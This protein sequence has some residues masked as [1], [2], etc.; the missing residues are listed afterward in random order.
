MT[1]IATTHSKSTT[2]STETIMTTTFK[3]IQT[4]LSTTEYYTT[5]PETTKTEA[6]NDIRVTTDLENVTTTTWLL[7]TADIDRGQVENELIARILIPTIVVLLVSGIVVVIL[8]LILGR[9]VSKRL[10][11]NRRYELTSFSVK[12][13]NG[14]SIFIPQMLGSPCILY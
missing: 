11:K 13:P 9:Y 14:K 12:A 3:S 1:S 7:P 2:V 4:R 8:C 5:V 10:H 6:G